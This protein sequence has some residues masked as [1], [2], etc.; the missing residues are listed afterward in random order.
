M[1]AQTEAAVIPPRRPPVRQATLVRGEWQL[2]RI[3]D[4]LADAIY[5]S[6]NAA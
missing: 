4:G 2:Q 1:K 6:Q 3:L 5:R